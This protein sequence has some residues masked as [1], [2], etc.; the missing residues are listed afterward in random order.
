MKT[1]FARRAIVLIIGAVML[2]TLEWGRPRPAL[3][4][5]QPAAMSSPSSPSKQDSLRTSLPSLSNDMV[6]TLNKLIASSHPSRASETVRSLTDE[7][8]PRL[9]GSPGD[10]AA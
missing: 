7:V 1:Q 8:G 2:V 6:A 5:A 9:A 3:A 10:A 4:Q